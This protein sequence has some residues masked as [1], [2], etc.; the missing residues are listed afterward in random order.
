[1]DK[2]T[3][4]DLHHKY[5][6]VFLSTLFILPPCPV[7]TKTRPGV[8]ASLR[9]KALSRNTI[10]SLSHLQAVS[11]A[12][13]GSYLFVTVTK[14]PG[15]TSLGRGYILGSGFQRVLPIMMRECEEVEQLT[16]WGLRTERVSTLSD[17]IF[18]LLS[19]VWYEFQGIFPVVS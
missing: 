15:T 2:G 13:C 9:V 12:L 14:M 5:S 18:P 1:M 10:I 3:K 8:L 19:V 16:S 17:S 7:I 4:V 6:L 11:I